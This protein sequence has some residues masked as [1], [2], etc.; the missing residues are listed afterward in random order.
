[1]HKLA[2]VA[3]GGLFLGFAVPALA[4]AQVKEIHRTVDLESNG[5]VSI[6]TFKGWIGVT[7]WDRPQVE[8]SARIEPD[9]S[10]SGRD[11]AEKVR[12]TEVRITASG[13]QVSIKTD[14][15]RVH[16]H[17]LLGAFGIGPGTL[18]F[19]VYA[20]RMPRTARLEIQDYKSRTRIAGLAS[21]LVI[22]TYKGTVDVSG[23][24][25]PVRLETY[26]GDVHAEY[27]RFARSEF[28]TYKGEIELSIPRGTAFSLDADAGRRGDVHNDFETAVTAAHR[29][30]RERGTSNGGGPELRLRTHKG[31]FRIRAR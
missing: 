13:S 11:Q 1:M 19:A 31:S 9:D 10:D 6:D 18:P 12:E 8:I 5:R 29:D 23:M 26:K 28:K 4:A 25:G 27:A 30:G 7:T 16:R 20:I 14:Y 2:C 17:G 3:A 15:D 21:E 24:E 22:K